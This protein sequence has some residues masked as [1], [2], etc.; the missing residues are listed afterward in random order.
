MALLAVLAVGVLG[1][2]CDDDA[3]ET[4]PVSTSTESSPDTSNTTPV[5]STERAPTTSDAAPPTVGATTPEPVTGPT[6]TTIT[7]FGI[8]DG[9]PAS[10]LDA[11][12][13]GPD[14]T[15][16]AGVR[17]VSGGTDG[18][19]WARLDGGRFVEIPTSPAW[20]AEHAAGLDGELWI[21][22]PPGFDIPQGVQHF[23]GT[24]WSFDPGAR[25]SFGTVG[26]DGTLFGFD[27]L[28]DPEGEAPMSFA[29]LDRGAW[30]E[31]PAPPREVVA[32]DPAIAPDG[33]LWV[34][35]ERGLAWFDGT[36]W[37]T[38]V[39]LG[40]DAFEAFSHVTAG[41]FRLGADGTAWMLYSDDE[42]GPAWL[43]L[44]DGTV[45]RR[46]IDL[47]SLPF[48][49]ECD[50]ADADRLPLPTD[51]AEATFAIAPLIA[52]FGGDTEG[53]LWTATT[54]LG[55]TRTDPIT[56]EL[57]VFTTADGMPTLG[58][59]DLAAHPDGSVW[60]ATDSGLVRIASND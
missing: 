17:P 52:G 60:V 26:S 40:P 24:D 19:T 6:G 31:L 49:D 53:R 48:D 5:P 8:D 50:V 56:G 22:G 29:V 33:T 34:R 51:P 23:D 30:T 15:V 16:W 45:E 41:E 36:E 58:F 7:T 25:I 39:D 1:A 47:A 13:V 20:G 18:W 59:G 43:R 57:Q 21:F 55:V 38:T 28:S 9:L 32:A 37:T 10:G 54:C 2:S 42:L 12:E 27:V 44:A 11:V 46:A 3:S 35:T 14:G 4:E